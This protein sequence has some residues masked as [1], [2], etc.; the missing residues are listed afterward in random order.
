M[1]NTLTGLPDNAP[2][3]N[4]LRDSQDKRLPRIAGPC[5]MVIFGVTGDLARKKLLPAIYDL[6]NRGLL[7]AGFALVGY[8]RREWS[9]KDFEDYVHDAV[10][11]GART[12]V[13]ASVWE[14]LAEGMEF[15]SGTFRDDEA[16]DRLGA[17]LAELDRTRGTAGNWGFYLSVP[18]DYFSDVCHQLKRSG[19][20]EAPANSWRRVIIEKPFGHDQESA[21]EL[22]RIV[23]AVFPED[24][25]FRIDHYLGKETVQNIMALRFANQLF[26]PLW[27]SHYIDHVQITMAEDIGLGGRAGYYD[28]IGAARDV[29]QNH[30]L[31]LLALT[32]MEEPV[33]FTP[34]ELQAEKIK[35]LRA[36]APVHPLAKTTARGQY[37]T[38]WQ[39]S[40]R[41]PG[42]REEEGFADDSNTETYAACT[43][44]IN[45]RRWAGVPFYL[46]TGKRLGRRVTEIALIFKPA[47]H[48]PFGDVMTS[49]LGQNAVVIR[50]QPDEGVLM[51]FGSKVPGSTMEVRDV[52][53][54]FSYSEAFTEESP[55]AYERL[56][57]DALLDE[58]SLF[59]TNEEVEL[60]WQILDPI[61]QYWAQRGRPEEYE[62][63]TWGPV[64]ADR[65]LAR[66]GRTWRRP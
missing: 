15:V 17:K 53:M 7:P 28:G 43:L 12:E 11:A 56:I 8:G 41:V 32:A 59:P 4:P 9:K 62:A 20:A 14:R 6:A 25:V 63:G 45:S 31:Q 34:A 21:R 46:R 49:A 66:E 16:F 29:I 57:L 38:G 5:G 23:N 51:R 54:D 37:T 35:V 61:I 24:S 58:S 42:L 18:P 39:G 30:L 19:M 36:T 22:N 2:W 65:M 26:D 64:S 47:P 27:N 55:E 60:S 52:N 13:R 48:L 10:V 33:S 1:S 3:F 44:E 50:V 40:T